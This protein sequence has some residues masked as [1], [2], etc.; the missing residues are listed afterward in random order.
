M[1]DVG[2]ELPQ[3][4]LAYLVLFKFPTSMQLLKRQTMH[5]DK[6]LNVL[7]ASSRQSSS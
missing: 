5:S 3:E 1:V 4:I 2:I 7:S 6:Q